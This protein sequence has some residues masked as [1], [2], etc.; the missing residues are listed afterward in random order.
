MDKPD[1]KTFCFRVVQAVTPDR[2]YLGKVDWVPKIKEVLGEVV[3]LQCEISEKEYNVLNQD[4][5]AGFARYVRLVV[6]ETD[7]MF[8]VLKYT[9]EYSKTPFYNEGIR[10][11][12]VDL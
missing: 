4:W 1:L 6:S 10:Y 2:A 5:S 9:D 12:K 3:P 7:Y 8:L 11:Q